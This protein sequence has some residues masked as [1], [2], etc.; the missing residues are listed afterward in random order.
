MYFNNSIDHI[1]CEP[2]VSPYTYEAMV[3]IQLLKYKNIEK[4]DFLSQKLQKLAHK[5][6]ALEKS[7]IMSK[8]WSILV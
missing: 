6:V 5:N 8:F 4:I 1:Q 3:E 2:E 7:L